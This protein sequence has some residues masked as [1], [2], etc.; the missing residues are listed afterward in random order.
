VVIGDEE[1]AKG[2]C[3]LRDMA[4]G[5]QREVRISDGPTELLRAVGG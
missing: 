1:L 2:V 5:E 4:S 3:S